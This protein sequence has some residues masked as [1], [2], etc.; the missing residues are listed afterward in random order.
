MDSPLD[1][2]AKLLRLANE[3]DS[4]ADPAGH[5]AGME[6]ERTC[7]EVLDLPVVEE[8]LLAAAGRLADRKGLA[9]SRYDYKTGIRSMVVGLGTDLEDAQE[10][11]LRFVYR[12]TFRDTPRQ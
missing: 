6:V 4:V 7:F 1:A 8:M 12:Q 9:L 10:R 11:G 2:F 5:V 3:L